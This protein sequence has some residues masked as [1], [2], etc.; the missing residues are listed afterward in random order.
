M[1]V[2]SLGSRVELGDITGNR[3]SQ[4]SRDGIA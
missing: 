3:K 1:S 4:T 2:T